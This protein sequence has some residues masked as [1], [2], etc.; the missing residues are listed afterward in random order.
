MSIK[1][2]SKCDYIAK[3][4]V[5]GN[6]AVGKTSILTRYTWTGEPNSFNLSHT[7]TIGLDFKSKTIKYENKLVKLQLWDTAGQERFRTITDNY[8]SGVSGILLVYSV[9]DRRS[10]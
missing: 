1:N 5:L 2:N 4:I 3:I 8:Y 9:T 6:S 7:P 10:F